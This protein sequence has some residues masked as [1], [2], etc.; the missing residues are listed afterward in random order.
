MQVAY[1]EIERALKDALSA[2]S[3][4][5]VTPQLMSIDAPRPWGV[6]TNV[7]FSLGNQAAADEIA[8]KTGG[9]GKKE[10]KQAAS[11][12]AREA[13]ARLAEEVAS[14]LA[15]QVTE[16]GLPFVARVEAEGAYLN[17][18]YD[19]APLAAHVVN[20][21]NKVQGS[22]EKVQGSREKVQGNQ[23]PDS[24]L[25]TPDSHAVS[26]TDPQVFGH[27]EPT[28]KRIM[29]EYAQPNTHK[30]FHV[31]HLRNASIGQAIANLLEFAGNDVLKAT[32]I[33]DV[34]RHVAL[35]MWGHKNRGRD[36]FEKYFIKANQLAVTEPRLVY[37]GACY[38]GAVAAYAAHRQLQRTKQNELGMEATEDHLFTFDNGAVS[39]W[40]DQFKFG[41]I[42]KGTLAFKR[43]MREWR[44]SRDECMSSLKNAF[45]ELRL[46][47]TTDPDCWFYE[48]TVDKTELDKQAANELKQLGIAVVDESE[49][50]K[51]ALYVDLAV[52]TGKEQLGKM[53]ILRSDG[54]SLYQTKELGLAKYKFDL[55]R[56][57]YG[58]GLDESLYI[59]GAEQ[60]L[61]FEQIFAILKLWGFP[62]AEN[63]K[64]VSYEL[65]V[66]PEGKMSSREGN[67]VSYRELR[68]EAVRRAEQI[69]RDKGIAGVGESGEVDEAKLAETAHKIAIAAIKYAMLQ[70]TASQQ[71]V[72]DFEQALSFSG[73]AAPYL[74]YAYARA[75]KLVD[76]GTGRDSGAR[77]FQPGVEG[78][79]GP[80]YEAGSQTPSTHPGSATAP[81]SGAPGYELHP[82]E[83]ELARQL[84]AFPS[85]ARSAAENYEPATLCTYLYTIATAFSDFYRDC[86]V[87][88]AEEPVRSFRQALTAA[89]RQV[90]KTGF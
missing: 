44:E 43:T 40:L 46:D 49:K 31:G 64:H 19:P 61:Y 79:F 21:V 50:Y 38:E 62:N 42:T 54:T 48:S 1:E 85:V 76:G 81:P 47:F 4:A 30:D 23:T 63:C 53:T 80:V 52:E 59:V 3:F 15:S 90:M 7:C 32:Y 29:V 51:G 12:L 73:R 70:V 6:T 5:D 83:A 86:R 37:W 36:Q 57:K 75:G 71:I 26:L 22:R 82:S 78:A 34:G 67:I 45:L 56:E 8:S 16:G 41:G 87:L 20:V 17:F 58:R 60:K 88:D 10:A 25:R 69:T 74:Q 84:S 18:Y 55:V 65:V 27:G 9:L 39:T 35:A 89:F 72:F 77:N 28:G 33:G 66:L 11:R 2:R 68:D 13:G 24:G 14:A